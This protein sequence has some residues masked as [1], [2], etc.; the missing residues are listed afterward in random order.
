MKATALADA[1]F[2]NEKGKKEVLAILRQFDL[3]E[4]AIEAE[5]IRQSWSDLESVDK[6]LTSLRSRF[7]R[8][9]RSVADYRDSL[10][11]R[12]RQGSE[13]I[14]DN[15]EIPRLADFADKMPA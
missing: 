6:M 9:L 15:D 5:A 4:S 7:D 3:D 11:K 1:W 8:T 14:L 2:T 13:R 12:M 10:A